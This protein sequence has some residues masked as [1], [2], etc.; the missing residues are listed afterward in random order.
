MTFKRYASVAVFAAVALTAVTLSGQTRVNG[1][2]SN[3]FS[4]ILTLANP[5]NGQMLTQIKSGSADPEGAV[6]APAGSIY[7]RT[8]GTVYKKTSGSGNTDWRCADHGYA[9]AVCGDEL[10][11]LRHRHLWRD[12]HLR[13]GGPLGWPDVYGHGDGGG[14]DVVGRVHAA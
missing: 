1:I 8:N 3:W 12:G 14:I 11:E 10:C 13:I 6:S 2:W 9:G 4:S 7:L 5:N